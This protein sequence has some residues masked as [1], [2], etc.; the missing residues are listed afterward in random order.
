MPFLSQLA[1]VSSFVVVFGSLYTVT[2]LIDY[3][4]KS[5]GYDLPKIILLG[6]PKDS[7]QPTDKMDVSFLDNLRDNQYAQ[8]AVGIVA[9]ITSLVIYYKFSQGESMSLCDVS[10]VKCSLNR[11]AKNSYIRAWCVERIPPQGEDR[12]FS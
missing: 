12:D 6:F 5:A 11:A 3:K 9:A 8:I 1:F 10:D 4:L 2:S 7:S